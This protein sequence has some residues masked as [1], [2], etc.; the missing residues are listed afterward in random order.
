MD[1]V[2]ELQSLGDS[3]HLSAE[4]SS[5]LWT[6]ETGFSGG[7][8]EHTKVTMLHKGPCILQFGLPGS[9]RYLL[10]YIQ[11]DN[12]GSIHDC[13]SNP[14]FVPGTMIGIIVFPCHSIFMR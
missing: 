10:S 13:F 8:G 2:C 1:M 7:P 11:S 14:C 12:V 6:L 4:A 9:Q 3:S 5:S